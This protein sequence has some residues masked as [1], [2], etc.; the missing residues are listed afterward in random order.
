MAAADDA[1]VQLNA[2]GLGIGNPIYFDMEA[3][4]MSD[5][6]CRQAVVD[7]LDAWT[8]QLHARGYVSGVYGSANSTIRA[9]VQQLPNP[10][11]DQPDQLWI[12]RWCNKDPAV[13]CD[14]ST[15]D[16]EVPADRW[17]NHQRIRQYRG[18]HVETWG[19]V[20]INIDSNTVDAAVAPTD[21]AAEGAFVQVGGQTDELRQ[22]LGEARRDGRRTT[23]G[24]RSQGPAERSGPGV[25]G[26]LRRA[27]VCAEEQ[28]GQR[29]PRA[30]VLHQQDAL[31][32]ADQGRA[33]VCGKQPE[34]LEL[35]GEGLMLEWLLGDGGPAVRD[36]DPCDDRPVAE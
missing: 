15:N 30:E 4:S 8:A 14:S 34:R 16:A 19:G 18:G 33:G 35:A 1:I 17:N 28:V 20:S 10:A 31:R 7:F 13:P 6:G 24:R 11:F 27:S 22:A 12:A 32:R 25:Q 21:L 36:R 29:R 2:L 23:S 9:L 26:P 3:F 5:V